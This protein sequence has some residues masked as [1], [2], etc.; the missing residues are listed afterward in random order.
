MTANHLTM[1]STI[2]I[3]VLLHA[4]ILFWV[5]SPR[6]EP[7]PEPQQPLQISL[8][9]TVSE[10]TREALSKDIKKV[11]ET[12]T[13]PKPEPVQLPPQPIVKKTTKPIPTAVPKRVETVKKVVKAAPVVKAKPAKMD[14]AAT[15]R[16]EQL[17]VAW[18][19]KHKKYPRRAKR[20]RIEGEG[21]LRILIDRSGQTL[22]VSLAERTGSRLL[23]KAALDMVKRANPFPPMHE[24]D[25]R[26]RM[27]FIVPVAF[28]LR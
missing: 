24:N 11:V 2:L 7:L 28:L 10:V 9:A 3:A 27:E 4:A 19:E 13:L 1:S 8:L 25:Q 15:A 6:V 26:R 18:L 17:L 12:E 23:D 14:A 21:Q 5:A 20:L 16:Y 22:Q